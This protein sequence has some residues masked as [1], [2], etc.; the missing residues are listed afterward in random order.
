MKVVTDSP[1]KTVSLGK[2]FVRCLNRK[3]VV[4]LQGPLGAGK[5]TFMKGI[6]EGF[7]IRTNVRSPTFVLMREYKNRTLTLYHIDLYRLTRDDFFQLGFGDY[8]Y[9]PG[10]IVVIEW[11]EKLGSLIPSCV[12]VEFSYKDETKRAITFSRRGE[13]EKILRF[14]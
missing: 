4:L 12:K 11:G 8:L 1:Q 6:V 7:G 2:Q 14:K 9:A 3:D 5:T 10:T 13:K